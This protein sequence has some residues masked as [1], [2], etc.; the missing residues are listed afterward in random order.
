VTRRIAV[1]VADK[2]AETTIRT[3]LTKRH[4]ALELP[5]LHEGV[6]FKIVNHPQSDP[7]VFSNGKELVAPLNSSFSHLLVILDQEWDGTPGSAQIIKDQ[8]TKKLQADWDCRCLVVVPEPEIDSWLWVKGNPHVARSLGMGWDEIL[9]IAQK[10]DWWH[11]DQ[12]KPFRPKEL[13]DHIIRIAKNRKHHTSG[14][15]LQI[16]EKV[17][18]NNCSD[19]SFNEMKAWLQAIF[20]ATDT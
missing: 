15:F 8:L 4:H 16:A 14:I 2:D 5:K 13:L 1:L 17:S 6:N 20:A 12:A 11:P 9:K 18:L 3:L 7:G 19:K 10:K